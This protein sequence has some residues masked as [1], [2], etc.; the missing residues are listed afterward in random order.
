MEA[1]LIMQGKSSSY[2]ITIDRLRNL[3]F[4]KNRYEWY[5]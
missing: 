1:S 4:T 2:K 3:E 5:F